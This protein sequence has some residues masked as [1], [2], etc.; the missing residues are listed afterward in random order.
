M[1]YT[2]SRVVSL[3]FSS[4][5]TGKFVGSVN[6]RSSKGDIIVPMEVDVVKGILN[7]NELYWLP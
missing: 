4:N 3:M 1:P 6:I 2:E 5:T 7:S